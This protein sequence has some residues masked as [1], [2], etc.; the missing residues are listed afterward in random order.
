[1]IIKMPIGFRRRT[2]EH[3]ENFNKELENIQSELKNTINEKI[4]Y[5]ESTVD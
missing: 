1:M 2:K 5:K 4:H 3:S